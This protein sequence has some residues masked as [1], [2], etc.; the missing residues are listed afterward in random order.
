MLHKMRRLR[1]SHAFVRRARAP[2]ASCH[3][4]PGAAPGLVSHGT[5]PSGCVVATGGPSGRPWA[6]TRGRRTTMGF[7]GT[8]SN[9]KTVLCTRCEL[10]RLLKRSAGGALPRR[11]DAQP[12]RWRDGN[13]L[14][15]LALYPPQLHV[16][17]GLP[18]RRPLQL[19]ARDGRDQAPAGGRG[20]TR[21]TRHARCG[22]KLRAV[23]KRH[24]GV[25][26][27]PP[28]RACLPQRRATASPSRQLGRP[29]SRAGGRCGLAATR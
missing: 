9:A 11:R 1:G 2:Q 29:S 22:G 15:L 13:V 16:P 4:L 25:G 14:F 19:R 21:P 3:T 17:G 8:E 10:P 23:V 28:F 18:L 5:T 7:R 12:W 27:L 26:K 20:G 24:F 6:V